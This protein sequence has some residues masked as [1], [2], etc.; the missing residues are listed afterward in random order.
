MAKEQNKN[1]V[2]DVTGSNGGANANDG[3][4]AKE[5]GYRR[6]FPSKTSVLIVVIIIG[7][8]LLG[9]KLSTLIQLGPGISNFPMGWFIA[10]AAVLGSIVNEPFREDDTHQTIGWTLAYIL[11]KCGVSIIFAFFLYLLA[12]GG[13]V[14]GELFPKFKPVDLDNGEFWNIETFI[15]KVNPEQSKDI[16]KILVWSFIAGYSERLIPNLIGKIVKSSE[17]EGK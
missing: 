15:K 5:T 12:S 14:G 8:L 16:A 10:T 4:N 11:W 9:Y 6:Y 17:S 7:V 1:N 13:L 2:S 3:A